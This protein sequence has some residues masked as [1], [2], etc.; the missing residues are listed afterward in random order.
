MLAH[1]TDANVVF[2]AGDCGGVWRG[3]VGNWARLDGAN[4]SDTGP[5]SDARAMV[6][7]ANGQNILESSDGGVARLVNPD[8]G[9]GPYRHWESINANL[10]ITEVTSVAYDPLNQIIWGGTQDNG[11][12]QQDSPG[13]VQTPQSALQQTSPSPQVT[14]PHSSRGRQV[15]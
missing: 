9:G 12:P 8:G 5:H 11:S 14:G 3:S 7:D 6:Y 15:P 10:Q 1:R 13:S 4:S 2:A